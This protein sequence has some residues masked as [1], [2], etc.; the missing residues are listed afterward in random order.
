MEF[1]AGIYTVG[2]PLNKETLQSG[3]MQ[4]KIFPKKDEWQYMVSPDLDKKI[5]MLIYDARWLD[6]HVVFFIL[7]SIYSDIYR[8]FSHFHINS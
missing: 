5:R 1:G 4:G 3:R 2:T 8:W 7:I 6:H